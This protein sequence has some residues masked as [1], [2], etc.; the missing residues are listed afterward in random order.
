MISNIPAGVLQAARLARILL[1][2]TAILACRPSTPGVSAMVAEVKDHLGSPTLFIDGKPEVPFMFYGYADS[3]F[4][5]TRAETGPEWKE[6]VIPF[7]AP[8]TNEGSC[9]IHIRVG[10]QAGKVWLDEVSLREVIDGKAAGSNLVQMGGWEEDESDLRNHWTLWANTGAGVKASWSVD[11][12]TFKEGAQ[13]G[14]IDVDIPGRGPVDAHLIQ[15]GMSVRQGQ[16]Y[17]L[18]LWLRSEP[19]RTLQ[20][21]VL[22]Q[23]EPW[24]PYSCLDQS[25]YSQQV[26]LAAARG[27]HLHSFAV[28]MPWPKPGE[29]ADFSQVDRALKAVLELDPEA[30]LLPRFSMM[31]PA[32]WLDAHPDEEMVFSDGKTPHIGRYTSMA[33]EAWRKESL[34]HLRVF[35]RHCEDHFGG[36][37]IG[38]HP[39]GQHTGEW[40]YERSWE[41]VTSGYE[42]P[43]REGFARWALAKHGSIESVRQAWN[44]PELTPETITVPS[45]E[46]RRKALHGFFRDPVQ[47]RFLIDFHEYQQI[48]M[49]EALEGISKTIKEETGRT[50]LVTLF[51]GYYF[52]ISGIPTGPQNSGHLAMN[53]LLKCPDID[54]LCSPI[55]YQDRG[56]GGCGPFMTAVDSVSAAG[57]L[58]LNE[59]D[60]RTYLTPE[61]TFVGAIHPVKDLQ[62]LEWVHQRNVGRILPRRMACWFMDLANEGWLND[63]A[64]WDN[65]GRLKKIYE[66]FLNQP[67]SRQPE[68]AVIIDEYSPLFLADTWHL[69]R[70][71]NSLFRDQ[72]GRIG[73]D[74]SLH[75]LNDVLEDRYE[76]PKVSLFIGCHFLS[77][78]ARTRLKSEMPGKTTV[79][80]YG[81]GC[82]DEKSADAKNMES[83]L[84]FSFK[85]H[86]EEGPASLEF[87]AET[88]P[89]PTLQDRSCNLEGTLQ[90]WWSIQPQADVISLG[91][92]RNGETA[93]AVRF[94]DKGGAVYSIGSLG[95]P[96]ELLR[97]ILAHAGVQLHLES[98]DCVS[99]DGSFLSIH[100]C[101]A[102][103]KILHL[104][105]GKKLA[106]I[107]GRETVEHAGQEVRFSMVPGENCYFGLIDSR[108]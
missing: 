91:Q 43:F 48:A 76:L 94:D 33:S 1:L 54:I 37:M 50:R 103:E 34:E 57:K 99:G 53:R 88:A 102:G 7:T 64:I 2:S 9:A 39:C 15:T 51:Y 60:T 107:L 95:C 72:Y 70:L 90:P 11:R 84:G 67:A 81:S 93:A 108:P 12:T 68:V 63:P 104:P 87:L 16:R 74:F 73:A 58:W 78:K 41:D 42:K 27:I 30:F 75:Y 18:R 56:S 85:E 28:P 23:G 97:N 5:P 40:F 19:S 13:S 6:V 96:S 17:E 77:Q 4:S 38:Y 105:P 31:A 45:S 44:R 71:L 65:I 100:A 69:T 61:S 47:E 101:T 106:P 36:R 92:F 21:Q 46:E 29:E 83:L 55:S 22:R 24:T 14:R 82:L 49:A 89:L 79:W 59:D 66:S 52:E 35:V 10:D 32:W 86:Q 98:P 80:F 25:L 8:E 62:S 20:V 26:R 3:A